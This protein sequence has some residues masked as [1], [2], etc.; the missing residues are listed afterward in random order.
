MDRNAG[1][2]SI[3][4]AKKLAQSDAGKKLYAAL[5]QSHGQQ[6]QNAMAQAN[7]GDF[8]AVKSTLSQMMNS[9]EVQALLQQ[10]GG[11]TDG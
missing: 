9:P 8:S 7:A 3:E 1:N 10:M 11:K 6:L 4:E 2:I 5:Q